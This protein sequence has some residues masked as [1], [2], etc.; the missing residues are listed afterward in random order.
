MRFVL[1]LAVIVLAAMAGLFIYG[2]ALEPETSVIEVDALEEGSTET[3]SG[4]SGGGDENE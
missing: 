4:D 2:Q 1:I 3:E